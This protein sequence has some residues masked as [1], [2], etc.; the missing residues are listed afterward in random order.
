MRLFLVDDNELGGNAVA[1]ALEAYGHVVTTE[2]DGQRAIER[3]AASVYDAVIVDLSLGDVDGIA[4]AAAVRE[5]SRAIPII[6]TTGHDTYPGLAA[7]LNDPK[8]RLLRKPY[9]LALLLATLRDLTRPREDAQRV[10]EQ[11][12]A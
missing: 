11:P 10:G 12:R 9:E 1:F 5:K 3:L 8:T 2:Q 4:V 6:F 7:A